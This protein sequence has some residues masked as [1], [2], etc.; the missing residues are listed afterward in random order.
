M[1]LAR[2]AAELGSVPE[3]EEVKDILCGIRQLL[4]GCNQE[5]M[6]VL[7]RRWEV[8]QKLH[9]KNKSCKVL[10]EDIQEQLRQAVRAVVG[11][12]AGAG[13][14][15]GVEDLDEDTGAGERGGLEDVEEDTGAGERGGLEDVEE[16]ICAG[17][18]CAGDPDGEV[19]METRRGRR[20]GK[21]QRSPESKLGVQDIGAAEPGGVE[22]VV[23][24]DRGA[25]EPAGVAM[26]VG[27]GRR[28]GKRQRSPDRKAAVDAD[29][30]T[31]VV[32][33]A[34]DYLEGLGT[35]QKEDH[36]RELLRQWRGVGEVS[37]W[38]EQR[39]YLRQVAGSFGIKVP[40]RDDS[41]LA[42]I[43]T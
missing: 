24:D 6:R 29:L 12:N 35:G 41:S 25:G 2:L 15:G 30:A 11:A 3:T 39:A 36:V 13:E 27:R 9:G 31:P 5:A 19:A 4:A 32:M 8:P 16:D 42:A 23:A 22:A 18:S 21:R 33:N 28:W 20:R 26:E 7:A 34:A 37:G 40:R 14:R 43:S 10:S 1:A 17:K 38:H